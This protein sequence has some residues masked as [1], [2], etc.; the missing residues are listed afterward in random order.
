MSDYKWEMTCRAMEIAE[1]RFGCDFYDLPQDKQSAVF[2]E[3]MNDWTDQQCA[4]ADYL[5]DVAKEK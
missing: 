1:E 5:N 3:A 2:R 4:K